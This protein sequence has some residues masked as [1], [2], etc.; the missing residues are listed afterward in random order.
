MFGPV[1]IW[2]VVPKASIERFHEGILHRLSGLNKMQFD[3]VLLRPEEH[4]FAIQLRDVVTNDS[5]G[6]WRIELTEESCQPG[7]GD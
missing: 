1:L 3:V 6:Q 4:R 7:T 2:T 5:F